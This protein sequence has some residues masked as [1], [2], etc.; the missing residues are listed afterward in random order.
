MNAIYNEMSY[1]RN[2]VKFIHGYIHLNILLCLNSLSLLFSKY[3]HAILTI[4]II[5]LINSYT[6]KI[7][8]Q[9]SIGND[10]RKSRN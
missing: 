4:Q 6:Q 1:K 10:V 5:H 9:Q 2:L 7:R 3:K 8:F